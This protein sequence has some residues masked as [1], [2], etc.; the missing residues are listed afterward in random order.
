MTFDGE[1][2]VRDDK[3]E[4][5][6]R[7]LWAELETALGRRLW[8]NAEVVCEELDAVGTIN[9]VVVPLVQYSVD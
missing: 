1:S 7:R 5:V 2:F 8:V 9:S 3:R 4:L 6:M